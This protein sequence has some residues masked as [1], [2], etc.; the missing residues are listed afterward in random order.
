MRRTASSVSISMIIAVVADVAGLG[1]RFAPRDSRLRLVD[2][3]PN[4]PFFESIGS[5]CPS[6][7][8]AGCS[9]GFAS[10]PSIPSRLSSARETQLVEMRPQRLAIQ[11][12]EP[13]QL[14]IE[15]KLDIVLA[16]SPAC[17][18]IGSM[19]PI[20]LEVLPHLRRQLIEMLQHRIGRPVFLDQ[21]DGRLLA[22][23]GNARHVVGASP[24]SVCTSIASAGV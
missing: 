5:T 6:R 7:C 21:L 15:I 17:R 13:A 22:D 11:P 24:I 2:R 18:A 9:A 1:R 14:R 8:G 23:A 16:A 3:A 19:S 4:K 20:L 10:P 12:G